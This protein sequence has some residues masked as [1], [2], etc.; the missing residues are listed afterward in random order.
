MSEVMP[1]SDNQALLLSGGKLARRTAMSLAAVERNTM[2]RL[3]A[4]MGES[5]VQCE[6]LREIDR[7]ASVAMTG[8]AMLSKLASC[9]SANDPMLLDEI[10]AFADMARLVKLDMISDSAQRLRRL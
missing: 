6:K 1:V 7:Q 9:L 4:V 8:Q 5:L 2:L 10:R 3:A